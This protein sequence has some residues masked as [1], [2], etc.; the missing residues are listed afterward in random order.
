MELMDTTYPPAGHPASIEEHQ[1]RLDYFEPMEGVPV[2]GIA[3]WPDPHHNCPHPALQLEDSAL[4]KPGGL[5]WWCVECDAEPDICVQCADPYDGPGPYCPGC[6]EELE[7]EAT[8]DD[9]YDDDRYRDGREWWEGPFNWD[10]H[11]G[12]RDW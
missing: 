2:H 3:G 8:Y 7:A 10:G 1:A 12:G 9:E 11:D 4:G 5:E 6:E